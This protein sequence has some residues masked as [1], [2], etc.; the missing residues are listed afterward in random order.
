MPD[1]LNMTEFPS[2]ADL[3]AHST[4]FDFIANYRAL[5]NDP[6][7]KTILAC[8]LLMKRMDLPQYFQKI[9]C[10]MEIRS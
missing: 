4:G 7:R 10:I 5:G 1:M 2:R 6:G 9:W 3:A 8:L